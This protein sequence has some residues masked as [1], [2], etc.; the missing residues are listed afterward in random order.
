M[1]LEHRRKELVGRVRFEGRD[2]ILQA[3]KRCQ[4]R[5]RIVT[6][7]QDATLTGHSIT[8]KRPVLFPPSL[9]NFT[10]LR[11]SLTSK[12][13]VNRALIERDHEEIAVRSGLDIRDDSEVSSDQQAFTF[14][15]L[16]KG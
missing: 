16:V 5:H 13:L 10:D 1:R 3:T 4:W 6:N 7:W 12:Y 2:L 14:G 11:S 8:L 9:R 15:H